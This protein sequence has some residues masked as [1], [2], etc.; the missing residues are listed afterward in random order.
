[1]LNRMP[2]RQK[3]L[4][5]QVVEI[6]AG[7][8]SVGEYPSGSRLPSE[9]DLGAELDV[10]RAT[11]RTALGILAGRGLVARHH[12]I[13]TF[14]SQLS[15]IRNPLNEFIAFPDLI[16]DNGFDPGLLE[17]S[18]RE[19]DADDTLADM[20]KVETGSEL[21]EVGKV[22]TADGEPVIYCVN[23]IPGWV[24]EGRLSEGEILQPG[25]TQ[26]LFDFL[27]GRC[28][29]RVAYYTASIRAEL[30]EDC[31]LPEIIP[32]ERRTVALVIDEIGFNSD[33]IPIHRSIECFPDNRMKFELIRH[34]AL[35]QAK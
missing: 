10:S 5:D 21:L 32:Y 18:V 17:T 20:L 35:L 9:A 30:A 8:I 2:R 12:G 22:F 24:Y 16:A 33:E 13:G 31:G 23:H 15:S 11:V 27:E 6:L 34:P 26:P 4:A 28:G 7:R 19:V 3:S 14:V 29:Q 1:M 25:V